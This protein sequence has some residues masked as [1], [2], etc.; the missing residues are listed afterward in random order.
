MT[1]IHCAEL[2][3][4]W[5]RLM[6]EELH[7]L[8]VR[9]LCLAPGSRSTPLTMAAAGHDGFQRHT[10][11]DERGLGFAALGLAKASQ[12]PVAIITTSGTAVANLYPAVIEAYQT[13]VP[14]V[15]LSGDRPPELIACGANQAIIQPAIFANYA[16]RLDLPTPSL[17]LP[18]QALL[19]QLDQAM[20][21]LDRPLHINCMYREPLYPDGQSSPFE[22]YLAPIAAWRGNTTP[23]SAIP[24]I[25]R[26]ALPGP[27]ECNSFAQGKGIIVVGTL[28]PHQQPEQILALAR[29]LGWPVLADAQSQLRQA[30]GVVHHID[31]MFH[32]PK[33]LKLLGKAE[34]LLLIGGRLLSKRLMSFIA[35]HS[36]NAYW[37]YMSHTEN[38][39]PGHLTKRRFIGSLPM[40]AA[41]PWPLLPGSGWADALESY[42]LELEHQF[43]ERHDQGR[44]T[45]LSTIRLLSRQLTGE[46]Q[47]FI[48]NSLP[49]RLY[50]MLASPGDA[51]T[52]FTNRGAS[53]I[54]GLLATSCGV[55][56]ATAKPTVLVV[57]DLSL[58][59]DLNSL[60]LARSLK[61]PLVVLVLNND[62]G[63][64]FNLLP[65]PNES[66]RQQY[67]RLGHGFGFEGAANQFHL[68]YARPDNLAALSL[69]LSEG[70]SLEG[71]SVIEVAVPP[72]ESA[73]LIVELAEQIRGDD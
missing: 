32:H 48:G 18:P 35:S 26:S 14:L 23:W 15:V 30:D 16:R 1:T 65:V 62:G 9:H 41:L 59:H 53:G 36:W 22:S 58:L 24:P 42:S 39:D 69:A 38:L 34:N 47:L 40:L 12:T 54:D 17:D 49:I 19:A 31:Q 11:F 68:P 3:L 28:A 73:D 72:S 29:R 66:L 64:I 60:A 8:G 10:H 20:V 37:H 5:A 25:S 13:G 52:V 61:T 4:L 21:D 45:E 50:D 43:A 71:A 70:L 51:P 27:D 67:Y 2:N 7:R 6:L 33:A 55:A 46:H 44:L 63:S 56:L 57:G